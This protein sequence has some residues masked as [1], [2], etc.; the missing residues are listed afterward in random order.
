MLILFRT[1][2]VASRNPSDAVY[3]SELVMDFCGVSQL[4]NESRNSTWNLRKKGNLIGRTEI[5]KPK[6]WA[7]KNYKGLATSGFRRIRASPTLL[8][9]GRQALDTVSCSRFV[10]NE[11]MHS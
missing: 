6:F 8:H 10:G 5:A 1:P 4:N 3:V 9:S 7:P 11:R 2:T